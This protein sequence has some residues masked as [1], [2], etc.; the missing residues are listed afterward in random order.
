M[1]KKITYHFVSQTHWDREWVLSFEEYRVM[2]VDF[3]DELFNLFETNPDFKHFMTDGQSKW[4]WTT[5]MLNR[6]ILKN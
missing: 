2:L 5:L 6:K 1:T 3:W 4:L